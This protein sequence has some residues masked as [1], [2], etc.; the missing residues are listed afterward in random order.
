[1]KAFHLSDEFIDADAERQMIAAVA[2]RPDLFWELGEL[3]RPDVFSAENAT[4]AR[5]VYEIEE[6]APIT[7]GQAWEPARNPQATAQHLAD[8]FQRRL[9]AGTQEQL[10]AGLFAHAPVS[11]LVSQLE[12]ET[13]RLKTTVNESVTGNLQWGD[14]LV[15]DVLA[16]AIRLVEERA[17]FGA[18]ATGLLT[19]IRRLDEWLNGLNTGLHL[20]AGSPGVG[21]TTF[22][23]QIAM[24]VARTVPVVYVTFENSPANL[25]LK[26]VAGRAGINPQHVQR[27]WTDISA[28]EKAVQEWRESGQ[29]V[30]FI[31]GTSDLTIAQIRAKT[32]HAIHRYQA[33]KCLLIID[34]LQLWAK[35]SAE[36]RGMSSVREKVEVMGGALRE[37]ATTLN[38]PVLAL[39]S[40]N[41]AGGDY[42]EGK[43]K[44]ALDSLKESGDLEYTADVVM[45]LTA[46]D[47]RVNKPARAIDLTIAKNRNGEI[48]KI[49]LI[50]RPDLSDMREV[51]N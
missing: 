27:G 50:F 24:A 26:A 23:L 13:L 7:Q 18:V 35:M 11:E 28:L 42:G 19:G 39:A 9:L 49:E 4:W 2:R 31:E 30:A 38:V 34:Y 48:G 8:L 41:R 5:L 46:S 6:R 20:L 17:R 45:F 15:N 21:K 1:M 40:Q 16:E 12:S 44:A 36:M 3:L 10:A 47:R 29:R 22:A 51:A 32:R 37:L 43:G 25:I 14:A 33:T